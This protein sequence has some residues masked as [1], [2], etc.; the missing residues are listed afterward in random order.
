L[1]KHHD[2]L[3]ISSDPL[4]SSQR[5]SYQKCKIPLWNKVKQLMRLQLE[6]AEDLEC[7]E[8]TE[9]KEETKLNTD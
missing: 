9:R 1:S 2:S 8:Q 3:L 5:K 7:K 4:I 6:E